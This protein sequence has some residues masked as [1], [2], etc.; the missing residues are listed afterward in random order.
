M[1]KNYRIP[2]ETRGFQELFRF[3]WDHGVGNHFNAN[4]D[5]TPWTSEMLED[6]FESAGKPVSLRTIQQWRSGRH[7]PSRKNLHILAKIIGG[8]DYERKKIWAD[9]LIASLQSEQ[10]LRDNTKIAVVEILDAHNA[11]VIRNTNNIGH[12]SNKSRY[13]IAAVLG[14]LILVAVCFGLLNRPDKSPPANTLAIMSF[15]NLKGDPKIDPLLLGLK[16]DLLD[17]LK[18]TQGVS[19]IPDRSVVAFEKE[20][21][22]L[23]KARTESAALGTCE[24]SEFKA[25]RKNLHAAHILFVRTIEDSG[26]QQTTLLAC[27]I[28]TKSGTAIWQENFTGGYGTYLDTHRVIIRKVS[29]QIGDSGV[30]NQDK[31]REEFGTRDSQAATFYIK[32]RHHLK[33]WHQ[34]KR[35][36]LWPANEQF[37]LAIALDPYFGKAYFHKGDAYYHFA[38]GDIT[39]ETTSKAATPVNEMDALNLVSQMMDEAA[40]NASS[41]EDLL[42]AKLNGIFFSENWN[43]LRYFARAYSDTL[44]MGSGELEWFFGPVILLF[45]GEIDKLE[46][47]LSNRILRYDPFNGTAHAYSVRGLL[48]SGDYD[49]AHARLKEAEALT[50][51][52]RLE[53]VEGYL[54][55]AQS[56]ARG[57]ENHIQSARFLSPMHRDYFAAMILVLDGK[58]SEALM[59]LNSSKALVKERVHRAI[60]LNN[61][62]D[63]VSAEQELLKLIE[64]PMGD[65]LLTV[66]L[67]YGAAC[68]PHLLPDLPKYNE[69]F[70]SS[71]IAMLKCI[72]NQAE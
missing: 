7:I 60:G 12:K 15:E 23:G 50:F 46:M 6:S 31:W 30:Q 33:Y 26:A 32:G 65:I 62:G 64:T 20:R 57:L 45:T 35:R 70:K 69:R 13:G 51:N 38:A 22:S 28:E 18:R 29:E 1:K 9:A 42:Q 37:D 27:L 47:L 8:G 3:V 41:D 59:M 71:N 17:V 25:A 43:D 2:P 67:A 5:P 11:K 58:N 4:G 72:G 56:D 54:L 53:E 39:D 44:S 24:F 61:A 21:E 40:A 16:S 48:T 63:T 66:Q 14:C 34:D 49:G 52:S 19:I 36:D 10:K 68:G 55:Y